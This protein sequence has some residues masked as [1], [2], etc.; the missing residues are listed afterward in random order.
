MKL[1]RIEQLDPSSALLDELTSQI[2]RNIA[3]HHVVEKG[4][5]AVYE[6]PKL[7]TIRNISGSITC[8]AA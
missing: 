1:S 2:M 3:E 5:V 6:N 4:A 7:T 8:D